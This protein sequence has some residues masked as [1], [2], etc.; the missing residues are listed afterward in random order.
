MA[1]KDEYADM[2]E[3]EKVKTVFSEK[4]SLNGT[5]RFRT[6]IKIEGS[7]RGK[8]LSEGFLII[9]ENAKVRANIKAGSIIIAGE[10]RGDV[11]AKERLEMLPTGKLYGNIKTKKLKMADGVVFEGSCEMLNDVTRSPI[12]SPD[13]VQKT[14]D[15][16][17]PA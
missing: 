8:I 17:V 4:T 13:R 3:G 9:G 1:K 7:F 5:L 10:V 11:D 16:G 12:K 14:T 6:S 2:K 15:S